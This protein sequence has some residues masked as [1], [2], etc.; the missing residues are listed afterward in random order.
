MVTKRTNSRAKKFER[1]HD[2]I[3]ELVRLRH[4]VYDEHD[5]FPNHKEMRSMH[6]KI[7]KYLP[8][9]VMV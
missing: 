9:L 4:E 7:D 2:R 6:D 3:V 8:R 5:R 1:A